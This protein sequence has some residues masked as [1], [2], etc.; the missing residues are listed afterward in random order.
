MLK[1]LIMTATIL[2]ISTI[3]LT[4]D[5]QASSFS[6]HDYAVTINL[7]GKQRMLTQ[8]MS[9]EILFIAKGFEAGK[10]RNTLK[11]TANIFDATLDGLIKGN[12]QLKATDN[13]EIQ[14]QLGKV[15][16]L[17]KKFNSIVQNV[18][19]G[20]KPD[21]EK[22]AS[23][24]I[25]LLKNMNAAVQM[26]AKEAKQ[27]TGKATGKVIN[28]AGKQRMLTQK[29]SKEM[30]FVAL[31]HDTANYT[32]A[33][34]NTASLFDKTLKGLKSGEKDLGLPAT[35][36]A[37]ILVQLDEV[38]S[39]WEKLKAVVGNVTTAGAAN[40]DDIKKMSELNIP[41]LKKMNKAVKMYEK[42]NN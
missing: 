1:K 39:I 21:L 23:Q 7:A 22:V 19:D 34:K 6:S 16:D 10:Y 33:L 18:V 15:K 9:K 29:M 32:A 41:L 12:K 13:K 17:W 30:L 28:L 38:A 3:Y 37:G 11:K 40:D 27:V 20:G 14:A 8:K 4:I 5:S 42:I 24:N 2:A 36:D 26:Y 31:G 25:P 35:S